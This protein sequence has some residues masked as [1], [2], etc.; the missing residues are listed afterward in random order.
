M[1]MIEV[2]RHQ[3]AEYFEPW[4]EDHENGCTFH[5]HWD[6]ISD[7]GCSCFREAFNQQVRRWRPRPS[8]AAP[9][10]RI[11][12][13]IVRRAV[14]DEREALVVQDYPD[15][16]NYTARDDLISGRAAA[17]VARTQ[18]ERS[19]FWE[20]VPVRVQSGLRAG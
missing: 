4:I 20:R 8:G 11:P 13:T 15:F 19:P 10:P 18:S 14:M 17:S 2:K 16:I 1:L 7:E 3:G 5:F 6:D 9:G 12:I